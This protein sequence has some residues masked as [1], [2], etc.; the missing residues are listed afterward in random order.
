MKNLKK[1]SKKKLSWEKYYLNSIDEL[2]GKNNNEKLEA[3]SKI[4][5][6]LK[7]NG[8]LMRKTAGAAACKM[9]VYNI[10]GTELNKTLM[11]GSNN[12]LGLA[13]D[14][15]V[16]QETIDAIKKFGIGC[17]G[18]PVAN[19]YTILHEEL[20]N[21]LAK[22]KGCEATILYSSG[23]AANVGW[24][25]ALLDKN[26]YLVYD[27]LSHASLYDGIKMAK[28]DAISFAHNDLNDL[29]KKLKSIR[30]KNKKANII[31]CVE[32]IFSMDGDLALLPETK[33]ICTKYEALLFV[34]DAHGTGVLGEQGHGVQ[35]H[36]KMKGEIDIIMGTFSKTFGV[37][38]GFICGSKEM[39]NYLR[40]FSRSYLFSGSIAISVVAS[41]LAGI[42]FINKNPGRVL[43]LKK[44][45]SYFLKNIKEIGY[46][47]KTESAI[48]PIFLPAHISLPKVI[49]RL[50]EEGIFVN[51]IFFPIVPKN[52]QRL[53]FSMMATFKKEDLDF[54]I[55]KIEKITEELGILSNENIR[56]AI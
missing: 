44:N 50:H 55:S 16:I 54:A 41:V 11:F 27:I 20:E 53:R 7:E 2:K 19:G 33:K 46:D 14:P 56:A 9:P 15:I 40:G 13:N 6:Y 29:E 3:F 34:D 1:S 45:T 22:M 8:V 35:E 52:K 51:G 23:Y 47:V 5:S 4:F 31:V 36:F 25:G 10:E 28:G 12:Y 39:I 48:I 30:E 42:N 49:K 38:G 32:S 37:A 17:G 24:V 21:K 26:D 18:P 43:Q